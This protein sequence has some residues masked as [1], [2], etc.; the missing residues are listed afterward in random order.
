MPNALAAVALRL[1]D[2]SGREPHLFFRWTEGNP[3]LEG[4]RFFVLGEGEIAAVT[5]E[6]LRAAE[7]D[8]VRR[9][10]VHAA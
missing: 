3:V 4:L 6:V 8:P 7:H 2:A 9:P 5:R 10:W 1:R